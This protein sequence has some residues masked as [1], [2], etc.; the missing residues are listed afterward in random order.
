MKKLTFYISHVIGNNFYDSYGDRLGKIIDFIIYIGDETSVE[1]QRPK[2]VSVKVKIK[3]EIKCL[4]FSN[5]T[6]SRIEKKYI[7]TC[8]EIKILTDKELDNTMYLVHDILDKQIVDINGRKIVRVND[9]RMISIVSGIYS[10]AVDVGV[11]GILR[12]IGISKQIGWVLSFF[13]KNIHSDFILWDDVHAFNHTNKNIK[14]SR[15]Y[16]KLERLHPS[17]LAEIIEDMDNLSRTKIFETLDEEKAADVLEELEPTTQANIIE[18]L[19]ITKAADVLEKMPSDEVADIFNELEDEKIELLLK[20]MEQ[21]TS[22][23]VKELL[24]YS[25]NEIGSIMTTDYISFNENITVDETLK[26][27]RKTKPEQD[28]LYSIFVTNKDERLVASVTLRTLVISEPNLTL[29]KIME[30]NVIFVYDEDRKESLAEI[31]SKY[32]LL[33]IPVTDSNKKLVGVVVIDDIVEDLLDKRR[34]S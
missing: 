24:E 4:D 11:E 25:K 18:S 33:S 10:I 8:K 14:L 27:L 12:R 22:N 32:N 31:I 26:E 34:T 3:G 5:F 7:F 16:N 19:S 6:I 23:E 21:V 29:K 20:E 2:V 1:S 13:N 17:D 15:S 30:K 9:I 28:A